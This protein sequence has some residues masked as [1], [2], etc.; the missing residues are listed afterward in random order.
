MKN[1]GCDGNLLPR[2]AGSCIARRLKNNRGEGPLGTSQPR[3]SWMCSVSM[4][5][6]VQLYFEYTYVIHFQDL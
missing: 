3:Y 4:D 2:A 1:K 5:A 6:H